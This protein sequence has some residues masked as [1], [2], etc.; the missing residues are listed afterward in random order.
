MSVP[1]INAQVTV[2]SWTQQ[3][4]VPEYVMEPIWVHVEGVPNSLRHFLGIWAVGTLI[5]ST[6]DVNLYTL[7]SQGIVRIQVAMRSTSVLQSDNGLEVLARLQLNGYRFRF[8]REASGYKPNPRFRPFFWK[9]DDDD[10][11]HGFEDK[12]QDDPTADG[13]PGSA[14]MEV[15]G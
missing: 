5:G 6:L 3:D 13:P 4:V 9:G 8:R 15:D 2:S 7:R 11:S 1:K 10:A 14:H 12:G